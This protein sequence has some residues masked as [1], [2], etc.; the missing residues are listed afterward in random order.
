MAA[1]LRAGA[2]R[3]GLLH[4]G[5]RGLQARVRTYKEINYTTHTHALISPPPLTPPHPA[6]AYY[7]SRVLVRLTVVEATGLPPLRDDG[8]GDA[9]NDFAG[10]RKGPGAGRNSG[11]G[12]N[13]SG[14]GGGGSGGG[15]PSRLLPS[16]VL[17][18]QAQKLAGVRAPPPSACTGGGSGGER[19]AAPA[20][21]HPFVAVTLERPRPQVGLLV[22]HTNTEYGTQAPAFGRN[23]QPKTCPHGGKPREAFVAAGATKL[24]PAAAGG[25]VQQQPPAFLFYAPQVRTSNTERRG[26]HT[27]TP[28]RQANVDKTHLRFEV[29]HETPASSHTAQLAATGRA[30]LDGRHAKPGPM[31]DHPDASQDGEAWL[32][33]LDKDGQPAGRLL[34][35]V[36]LFS[37][38]SPSTTTAAATSS[39]SSCSNVSGPVD[40]LSF[41]S[42]PLP[43]PAPV[44]VKP[45]APSMPTPAPA[46]APPAAADV[47]AAC[48]EW[49][50]Q[51]GFS[52]KPLR[53]CDIFTGAA[54]AGGGGSDRA[55][56]R[57]PL[58]WLKLHIDSLGTELGVL[59]AALRLW[60][61]AAA[62]GRGFRSSEHK[63]S[64]ELQG[65]ATNVHSQTF[66][67]ADLGPLLAGGLPPSALVGG[68]APSSNNNGGSAAAASSSPR[69]PAGTDLL[70][71]G[72]AT[73]QQHPP[74]PATPA[75]PSATATAAATKHRLHYYYDLISA[76][77]PTAHALGFR[78]GGLM[79]HHAEMAALQR[80]MLALDAQV[81]ALVGAGA[82]GA[83]FLGGGCFVCVRV[84]EV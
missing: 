22:G 28:P 51:A 13:G 32:P 34:M 66:V 71:G 3:P 81:Q 70:S 55:Q 17:G 68:D 76:G 79:S 67:L 1:A 21:A 80:E 46:P 54:A 44:T 42:A 41:D 6:Y 60:E 31:A 73:D 56:L 83:F 62:D 39:S 52:G 15:K 61:Q 58:E 69:S 24:L 74:P 20:A 16:V 7:H 35:R 63:V 43:P 29:F 75:S 49:T 8:G 50:R 47:T 9:N 19:A 40:L 36:A 11:V 77:A 2:D 30:L 10:L 59:Q 37:V 12:D 33:L 18:Q 23:S 26:S 27:H 78:A 82:E 65:V 64:P 38:P 57:Y 53:A 4:V 14:G 48:Y 5:G 25:M 84:V 72:L 45:P